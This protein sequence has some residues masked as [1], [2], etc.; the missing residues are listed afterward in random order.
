MENCG[1]DLGDVATDYLALSKKSRSSRIKVFVFPWL[2]TGFY[3]G[4][5]GA[6]T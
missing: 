2:F 4:R 5:H 6:S 1:F 3:R